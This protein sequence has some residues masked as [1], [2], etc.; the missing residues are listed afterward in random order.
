MGLTEFDGDLT[1]CAAL[2]ERADPHRFRAVMAA[3]LAARPTLFAL[4]AFNVE[5]SR[6]PWVTGEALIAEMRLQWWH[7]ALE[8]IASGGNVRRH[9]VVTPLAAVLDPAAAELLTGLVSARRADIEA[10]PFD[11]TEALL[12]YLDATSG[13]LLW[14]A[15]GALGATAASE[16]TVRDAA[17]ALGLANWLRAIPALEA[18]GKQPLPDGRPEAVADLARLGLARLAQARKARAGVPVAAMLPLAGVRAALAQAAR[19][20]GDVGASR[21]PTEGLRISAAMGWA[22]ATGRW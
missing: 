13:H 1:A 5:V 2:V 14:A 20:P 17:L 10:A 15:A 6:A 11:D 16:A 21:L 7:D 8:E 22:A 4:Y 12:A 18:A 9:E 3:P 19:R